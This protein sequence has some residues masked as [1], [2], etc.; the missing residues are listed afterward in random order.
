M[1]YWKNVSV[2]DAITR[3]Q[4][5]PSTDAYFAISLIRRN[6]RQLFVV[7]IWNNVT[8]ALLT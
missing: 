4:K 2:V 1:R 6:A 8:I 5:Y 3:P 7:W